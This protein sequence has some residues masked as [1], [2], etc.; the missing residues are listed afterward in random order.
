MCLVFAH[1]APSTRIYYNILCERVGMMREISLILGL[2]LAVYGAADLLWR[3]ACRLLCP[4]KEACFVISL[5]GARNDAE[6]LIRSARLRGCGRLILL[7][8]GLTPDSAALTRAVCER[9]RV[10]FLT[11]KEWQEMLKTAL[12]DE[13]K[14]V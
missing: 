5:C 4:C 13:K 14:G 6:Y 9:L 2:L 10:D 1:H 12:Q 11:E 8:R 7:D 3:L